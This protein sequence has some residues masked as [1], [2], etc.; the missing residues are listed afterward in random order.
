MCLLSLLVIFQGFA[1][2]KDWKGPAASLTNDLF[3]PAL[4]LNAGH[5]FSNLSAHEIPELRDFLDFKRQ[6]FS[7]TQLPD[8]PSLQALH[9]YQEFHRYLLYTVAAVW[10]CFGV[11]WHA[12]KVLLV[13]LLLTSA[14]LVYS[15]SRLVLRPV[16][17]FAVA[18]AFSASAPVFWALPVLRDFAKTPFILALLLILGWMIRHRLSTKRYG[19]LAFVAGVVMGMGLGFRRDLLVF[20]P[21]VL[22][23]LAVARFQ[24]ASWSLRRRAMGLALTFLGFLLAGLPVHLSLYREGNLAAHD[25]LMG[26]ASYSDKELAMLAPASYEKHY[27]LN[28]LFCTF[29][30]YEGAKRGITFPAERYEQQLGDPQFDEDVK[31]AYVEKLIRTFPADVLTR[32]YASVLR[33]NSG[34]LAA[35]HAFPR[36]IETYGFWFLLA[37][38]ILLAAVKPCETF[39]LLLLLCYSCG[40]TSLQFGVRHSVQ[41]AFLPYF[42]AALLLELLLRGLPPAW[43]WLRKKDDAFSAKDLFLAV[44]RAALWTFAVA[45]AFVLPLKAAQGFQKKQVSAL[46]ECYGAQKSEALRYITREWEDRI[47]FIPLAP[48]ESEREEADHLLEN[49]SSRLFEVRLS[50]MDSVPELQLV[51][52]AEKEQWDF[53]ATLSCALQPGVAW[54]QLRCFFPVHESSNPG[55]GS[56][57]MGVSLPKEQRHYFSGFHE[58]QDFNACDLLI[59]LFLPARREALVY[60]QRLELPWAGARWRD[61]PPEPEFKPF[62]AKTDIENA[63][64]SDNVEEAIDLAREALYHQPD[65]PEFTLLHV[66]AL[67]KAGREQEAREE[68]LKLLNTFHGSPVIAAQLNQYYQRQGG[69]SHAR[70]AWIDLMERIPPTPWKKRLSPY[71]HEE[72]L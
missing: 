30:A 8:E 57:F 15:L 62:I 55:E 48:E 3:I 70:E 9:P 4:M 2:L 50:Q 36:F 5:G 52:E 16:L 14:L 69:P 63:I 49:M 68:A 6:E 18:L 28:D 67:E 33:I 34:T 19:I 45:L 12:I 58:I 46:M 61:Y 26:F 37:S 10:Q 24:P 65:S 32:A 27:L 56:R 40:I 25:T 54:G 22:A 59:P 21:L 35:P 7:L 23:F 72:A 66:E 20:L 42:F 53:G 11:N 47:L 39:L 38:L 13:V 31:R 51:Y 29:K 17:S 60:G 43:H 71:V 44:R 1:H 41:L 64:I